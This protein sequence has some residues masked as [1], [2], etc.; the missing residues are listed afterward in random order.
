MN[1][2]NG[3]RFLSSDRPGSFCSKER[4]T[5]RGKELKVLVWSRNTV[6]II[7]FGWIQGKEQIWKLDSVGEVGVR[8]LG[9]GEGAIAYWGFPS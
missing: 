6:K 3:P 4:D 7:G 8:A 9:S 5:L 1:A 2:A